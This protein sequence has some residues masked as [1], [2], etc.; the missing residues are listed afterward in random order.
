[1]RPGFG[2]AL[3]SGFISSSIRRCVNCLRTSL[4]ILLV[5][6]MLIGCSPGLETQTRLLEMFV[7]WNRIGSSS[8]IWLVKHN[9]F[10]MDEKVAFVFGFVDDYGFC[11][12]VAEMYMKR[13]P[14]SRYS[15]ALAN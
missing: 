1:V 15:C 4:P 8:D 10:G 9:V 2:R 13:Y 6:F 5:G 12:E 7:K 14:N 3:S 11:R